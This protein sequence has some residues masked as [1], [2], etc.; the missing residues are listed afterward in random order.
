MCV[1]TLWQWH[2]NV[3]SIPC[4]FSCPLP[5][6][7][8]RADQEAEVRTLLWLLIQSHPVVIVW[9]LQRHQSISSTSS[10]VKHK[11]SWV[12]K[13]FFH[14]PQLHH[15]LEILTVILTRLDPRLLK[16]GEN[17]EVVSTII[18]EPLVMNT[19]RYVRVS[20]LLHFLWAT[21]QII[22]IF[23]CPSES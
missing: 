5:L 19:I 11:Q 22:W 8:S 1:L 9:L 10:I 20:L 4:T 14:P 17:Q 15:S 18:T 6:L 23:S 13:V 2:H 3:I 12:R 16:A 21:L 7:L